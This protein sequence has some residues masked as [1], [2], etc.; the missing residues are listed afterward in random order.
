MK[1]AERRTQRDDR[2]TQDKLEGLGPR[3]N[4][5]FCRKSFSQF[6][7]EVGGGK[8]RVLED[9]SGRNL[10]KAATSGWEVGA[11]AP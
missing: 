2:A 9:G 11:A 10:E 1:F 4:Q 7:L 8:I 3:A 6:L 5:P